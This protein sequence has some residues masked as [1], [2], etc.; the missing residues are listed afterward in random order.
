MILALLHQTWQLEIPQLNSGLSMFII[1]L[2]DG[3]SGQP[4]LMIGG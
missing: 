1:E 2:N 3:F 4:C